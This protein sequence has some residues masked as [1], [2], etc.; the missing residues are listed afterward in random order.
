MCAL[1]LLARSFCA[2][3]P[4]PFLAALGDVTGLLERRAAEAA[5]AGGAP[6]PSGG[7]EPVALLCAA[8][9]VGALSAKAF[10]HMRALLPLALAEV[11][12]GGGVGGGE[13]GEE[14]GTEK[15]KEEGAGAAQAAALTLL[16]AL[17]RRLPQ[18]MHPHLEGLLRAVCIDRG[19][20]FAGSGGCR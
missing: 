19:W 16:V 8:T 6:S 9:L 17:A 3:A 20:G 14:E 7:L 4:D 5:E 13:R 10:P 12:R 15:E 1:D 11:Q 2:G 18:F